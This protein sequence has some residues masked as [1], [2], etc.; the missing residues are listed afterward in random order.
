MFSE[1]A[2]SA[3]TGTQPHAP[4]IYYLCLILGHDRCRS[5]R[6]LVQPRNRPPVRGCPAIASPQIGLSGLLRPHQQ[7]AE[8]TILLY[9]QWAM[10]MGLVALQ[11]LGVRSIA[12]NDTPGTSS[13]CLH[14]ETFLMQEQVQILLPTIT[15]LS[16]SSFGGWGARARA[17]Q[18]VEDFEQMRLTVAHGDDGGGCTMRV[19]SA[20]GTRLN[21]RSASRLGGGGRG[22]FGA[23]RDD[24]GLIDGG[25]GARCHAMGHRVE[26]MVGW[27]TR[28]GLATRETQ[29][30][31]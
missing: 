19:I 20:A 30:N 16:S 26:R 4:L 27:C 9:G 12:R 17:R 5:R 21:T 10:H 1:Y 23:Q 25:M 29:R 7:R 6:R 14:S 8:A 31:E 2:R 3:H 28:K 22:H 13:K 18:V 11:A 15:S 24:H